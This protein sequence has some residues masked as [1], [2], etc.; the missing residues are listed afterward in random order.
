MAMMTMPTPGTTAS[1]RTDDGADHGHDDP[2]VRAHTAPLNSPNRR[3]GPRSDDQ[4]DPAPGRGVELQEV[5]V[6]LGLRPDGRDDAEEL[7][8]RIAANPAIAWKT[9][10]MIIMNAAKNVHPTAQ[11]LGSLSDIDIRSPFSS[12]LAV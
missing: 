7:V 10:I 6:A 2:T 9:P 12:Y 5:G 3:S 4:V 1:T 8:S 11:P